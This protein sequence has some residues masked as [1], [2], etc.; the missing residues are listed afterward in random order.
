MRHWL[1][2]NTTYGT[3]LPGNK[4]G[5]VTSVRDATVI[6]RIEHDQPGTPWEGH[7]PG[8]ECSAAALLKAPPLFLTLRQAEIVLAQFQET[9]LYRERT[10]HAISIMH[11]HWHMVTT[12]PGDPDPNR[13]LTDIKAY[14]SRALNRE[15]GKPPSST[16]WTMRGSKRKLASAAALAG[17]INYTL[18]KQPNPLVVW[19]PELGRIV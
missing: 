9:A 14:A 17:A 7:I 15:Y 10:L 16:W 1:F 12:V 13:L 8:I 3:W 18:Y 19:S 6:S 4:R 2:T 11:N 5:S